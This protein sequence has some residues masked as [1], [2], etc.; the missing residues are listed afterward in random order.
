MSCLVGYSRAP[1][2][3]KNEC[4]DDS[5][6]CDANATYADTDGSFTCTCNEGFDRS[7]DVFTNIDECA[8]KNA[9]KKFLLHPYGIVEL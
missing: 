7:G 3:D 1:C 8:P 5:N 2:T 4:T 9:D 6:D